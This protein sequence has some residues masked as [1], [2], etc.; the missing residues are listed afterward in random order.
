MFKFTFIKNDTKNI[1]L[2][3]IYFFRTLFCKCSPKRSCHSLCN[4]EYTSSN[5]IITTFYLRMVLLEMIDRHFLKP[6]FQCIFCVF[7]LRLLAHKTQINFIDSVRA[8][9]RL[10][11]FNF[12]K[13]SGIPSF[14]LGL[15]KNEYLFFFSLSESLLE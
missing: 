10:F 14:L 12:G 3:T 5:V 11:M 8:I 7:Q 15:W 13:T 4:C 6:N 1:I 2:L 9:S